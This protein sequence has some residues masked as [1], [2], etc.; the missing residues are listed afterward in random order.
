VNGER[1]REVVL[2]AGDRVQVG[3]LQFEM[4]VSERQVPERPAPTAVAVDGAD[5]PEV[6]IESETV[7][8]ST[9]E[10]QYELPS[11]VAAP[12]GAE[13]QYE[14]PIPAAD[15]AG[16]TTILQQFPA[17]Q[18]LGWAPGYP[19][20][21]A[22]YPQWPYGAPGQYYGYGTP[23]GA[24][25]YPPPGQFPAYPAQ[26][27]PP[28]APE[29]AGGSPVG[30]AVVAPPVRLPPPEETGARAPAPAAPAEAKKDDAQ[31]APAMTPSQRAA[32][33]IKQR[34]RRPG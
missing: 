8:L 26:Y 5:G 9:D 16:D 34:T 15:A 18:P 28:A 6:R 13:T 23:Y 11:P 10:T 4:V 22:M 12:A 25:G 3:K 32:E 29:P 17:Q 2:Q 27:P 1:I 24:P 19:P 30:Q 33:I 20:P 7:Q 31:Q 21:G 14:L